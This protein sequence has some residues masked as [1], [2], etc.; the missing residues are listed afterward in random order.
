[1]VV[2]PVPV[3]VARPAVLIVAT[4]SVEELHV[5]VLVR[6]RVVPSLKVPVAVNC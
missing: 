6:F 3:A 5:A 1:M 4:V 2:E